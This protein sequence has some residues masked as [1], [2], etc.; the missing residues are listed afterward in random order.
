MESLACPSL[1]ARPRHR[2]GPSKLGSVLLVGGGRAAS[3]RD[4]APTKVTFGEMRA[5]GVKRQARSPAS[6]SED[7]QTALT[8][9][10]NLNRWVG[11]WPVHKDGPG[12]CHHAPATLGP[13]LQEARQS[14]FAL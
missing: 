6:V 2:Q 14:A 1:A 8:L 3:Q 13:L 12:N 5:S 4:D 7:G 10:F 9:G 11:R